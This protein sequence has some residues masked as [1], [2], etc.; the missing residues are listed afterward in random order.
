MTS[1]LLEQPGGSQ[2][3]VGGL[4][5]NMGTLFIHH[6]ESILGGGVPFINQVLGLFCPELV[7]NVLRPW[8]AMAGHGQPWP[9]V[10]GHGWPWRAW[11]VMAEKMADKI[12]RKIGARIVW[13]IFWP[14]WGPLWDPR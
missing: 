4:G 6:R 11:R 13:P 9:A 7:F 1:Q 3:S 5:I 10:A 8:P 2:F 12:G 14:K